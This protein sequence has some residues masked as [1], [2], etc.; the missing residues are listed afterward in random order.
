MYQYCGA[1]QWG[2]VNL[3]A[4][5]RYCWMGE[6]SWHSRRALHVVDILPALQYGHTDAVRTEVPTSAWSLRFDETL[7]LVTR[8]FGIYET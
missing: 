1:S 6:P 8:P 7:T 5:E 4:M 2:T 3:P